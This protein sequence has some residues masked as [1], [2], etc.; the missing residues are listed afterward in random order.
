MKE[1]MC[2]FFLFF[3]FNLEDLQKT[4]ILIRNAKEIISSLHIDYVCKKGIS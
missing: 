2:F 3:F 4:E 1:V